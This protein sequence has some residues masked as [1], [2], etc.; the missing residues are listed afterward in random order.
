MFR[1]NG[2]SAAAWMPRSGGLT[3]QREIT[4]WL[5][6]SGG[7]CAEGLSIKCLV[8]WVGFINPACV[9]CWMDAGFRCA[10]TQPTTQNAIFPV[11]MS[12]YITKSPAKL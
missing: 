7:V 11:R 9:A 5:R 4:K 12:L 10:S 3:P 8:G 2:T 1:M 6:R